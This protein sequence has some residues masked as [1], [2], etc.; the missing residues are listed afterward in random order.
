MNIDNDYGFW[1]LLHEVKRSS[2]ISRYYPPT[3]HPLKTM[4]AV[5]G[6]KMA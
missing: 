4:K 3:A 2:D 1:R 5:K 6:K